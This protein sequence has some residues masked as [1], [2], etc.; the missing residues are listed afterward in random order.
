MFWHTQLIVWC[1]FKRE[2]ASACA[3]SDRFFSLL[4]SKSLINSNYPKSTPTHS[5]PPSIHLQ[6]IP[7]E[8]LKNSQRHLFLEEEI[9]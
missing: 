4:I 2:K 6:S 3:S 7:V 8:F 9:T 1:F 5:E